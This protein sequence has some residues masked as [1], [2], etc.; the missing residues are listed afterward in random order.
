MGIID[1][2]YSIEGNE[3]KLHFSE[4]KGDKM[5]LWSKLELF[6]SN[7]DSNNCTRQQSYVDLNRFLAILTVCWKQ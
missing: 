6:D 3:D 2:K 1:M 5:D 4:G 7:L